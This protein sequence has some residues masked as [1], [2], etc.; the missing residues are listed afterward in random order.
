MNAIPVAADHVKAY[1][2]LLRLAVRLLAREVD[3]ALFRQM[4]G[5]DAHSATGRAPLADPCL[6][7]MDETHRAH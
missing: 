4:L 1:S 3:V 5:A 2:G 6:G 7:Q